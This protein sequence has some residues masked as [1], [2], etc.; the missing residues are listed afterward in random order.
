MPKAPQELLYVYEERIPTDLQQLVLSYFPREEFD[1]KRMT[2]LTPDADKRDLLAWAT[3]VMFAPGRF[4]TDEVLEAGK[5]IKLMQLWSSGHDKFNVAGA[6]R[7]GIP[8]AN[9]GG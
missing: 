7:F 9:N 2:Y 4:L 8:V 1:I 6:R 5:N 3:L